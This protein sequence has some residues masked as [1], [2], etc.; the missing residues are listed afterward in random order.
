MAYSNT[1]NSRGK[2]GDGV[3]VT[4]E[5]VR[6][7]MSDGYND[8]KPS[9]DMELEVVDG[10]ANMVGNKYWW[11]GNLGSAKQ[12]GRVHKG[13]AAVGTRLDED[14]DIR[15]MP[16]LGTTQA[17]ALIGPSGF[18][19]N[20]DKWVVK[21]L[22]TSKEELPSSSHGYIVPSCSEK[23]SIDKIRRALFEDPE[24]TAA[25]EQAIA[26]VEL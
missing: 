8:Y 16:G 22:A 18:G 20:P 11:N 17:R 25:R 13:L 1:N 24:A 12:Q 23:A 6:A 9:I 15:E 10:S 19:K 3:W 2:K 7:K 5:V 14:M 26:E 21:I 4:V